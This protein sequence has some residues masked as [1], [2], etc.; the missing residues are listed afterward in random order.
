MDLNGS[1]DALDF[2]LFHRTH[3]N[4]AKRLKMTEIAASSIQP[5][6]GMTSGIKSIG[7][8]S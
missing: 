5:T 2:A 7:D 6:S 4:T 3:E 1:R 8:A